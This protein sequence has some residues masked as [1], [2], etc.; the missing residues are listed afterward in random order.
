[1]AGLGAAS[2]GLERL[3]RRQDFDRV[4]RAGRQVAGRLLVLRLAPGTAGRTRIG[5]AVG[6]Q[7]GGAVGRNR[8]RRRWREVVR[9]GPKVAG[10]WDLVLVARAPSR[11]APWEALQQAWREALE[12]AGLLAAGG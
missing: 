4:F 2:G 7:V 8:V 10:A 12:R 5:I 6:R 3:R 11:D 9:L 1:V